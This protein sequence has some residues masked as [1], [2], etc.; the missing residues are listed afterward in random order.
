MKP[1]RQSLT[2]LSL[3]LCL[4]TAFLVTPTTGCRNPQ[5]ATYQVVAST[6]VSADEAMKLWGAYVSARHPSVEQERQVLNA[7]QKYQA[8]MLLVVDA[9]KTYAASSITNSS[10]A[11]AVLQAAI[12]NAAQSLA[13]LTNLLTTFGVKLK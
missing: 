4:V 8:S 2:I 1:L 10:A 11:T 5:A 9:G 12:D 3:S 13:D 6:Q 7:Y